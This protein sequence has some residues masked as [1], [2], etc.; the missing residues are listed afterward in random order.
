MGFRLNLVTISRGPVEP[1]V[2]GAPAYVNGM[3]RYYGV[4]SAEHRHRLCT[5]WSL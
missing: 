4:F 1:P 2:S 3:R 5:A